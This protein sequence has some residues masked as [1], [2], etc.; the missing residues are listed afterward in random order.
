MPTP[1]PEPLTS[2]IGRFVFWPALAALLVVLGL[3]AWQTYTIASIGA[4]HPGEPQSARAAVLAA[5]PW[6]T[7]LIPLM[8]VTALAFWLPRRTPHSDDVLVLIGAGALIVIT[9][10]LATYLPCTTS[11]AWYAPV[12]W[13]LGLFTGAYEFSP[14]PPS[15]CATTWAPGLELARTLGLI[16]TG[17]TAL[18]LIHDFARSWVDR[19]VVALSG[20]VDVVAG[21]T[22]TSVPLVGALLD[23]SARSPRRPPWVDGR[24]L[25]RSHRDVPAALSGVPRG[26]RLA[27]WLTGLR[28]GDLRR[29]VKAR[30][31][32]VVIDSDGD[33]TLLD[34][35]RR[36]GAR[37]VV[38]D[39]TDER[40]LHSVLTRWSW[41]GRRRSALRRVF[42]VEDDQRRNLAIWAAVVQVMRDAAQTRL[43]GHLDD[44]VPRAFVLLAEAREARQ[45]RVNQ[46]AGLGPGAGAGAVG[47]GSDSGSGAAT[48]MLISDS[49][50]LD[51]LAA[52]QV[53][54]RILPDDVRLTE[55]HLVSR[56]VIVGDGPMALTL[57]DELAWQLWCRYEIAQAA[58][59]GHLAAQP[60]LVEITL[61]GPT[62][63]RRKAEWE[64]VR[65]PWC[66]PPS[67]RFLSGQG[68]PTALRMFEVLADTGDAEELASRVLAD[69][70]DA[71]VVFVDEGEEHAAAAAR[72][73]RL[74]GRPGWDAVRVM[75]RTPG[76]MAADP[77][78]PGGLLR[79]APELLRR[80]DGL[81]PCAPTDSVAR[82][83][84]QQH[85][86]Y[87][88]E[89]GFAEREAA[90]HG[91][92]APATQRPAATTSGAATA[93][94][95][96]V[97]GRR[98]AATAA[99]PVALLGEPLPAFYREDNV[100]QH[101][102]I[103]SWAVEHGYV[104][105]PVSARDAARH[106]PPHDWEP[107]LDEIVTA[108]YQRWAELRR[109]HGWW[110]IGGPT[111][112][113]GD[114]ALRDDSM[115]VHPELRGED[116]ISRDFNA[117]LI[118]TILH[119]LWASGLAAVRR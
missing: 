37:V 13:V 21:L 74:H 77:I 72:L 99:T 90:A 54:R 119:R 36:M 98:W 85:A 31:R 117:D 19:W 71:V 55:E 34:E 86:V 82:L 4:A 88:A 56:V 44:V 14:A 84:E 15:D 43:G 102:R 57:L 50:T 16:I 91:R 32:V 1:S 40:L 92:A 106:G 111:A 11:Q 95:P 68:A 33:N 69:D 75:L 116:F 101:W 114:A 104:W 80:D 49:L 17:S 45:W 96:K 9:L 108:E 30:T 10:G 38:G 58:G 26:Q 100:R 25:W 20:D 39:A 103:L 23:E 53:A 12:S 63:E 62:A 42:A 60:K 81:G 105:E 5:F 112:D 78:T 73:A 18:K 24:P 47:F 27:W 118:R 8:A 94:A 28:P 115:R 59:R 61:S 29:L 93:Y 48:P 110:A 79:F 3:L 89:T 65:A 51:G 66:Y 2:R 46:F 70:P 87:R 107:D 22:R 113:P 109:D 52:E 97:T 6:A 41:P 83:A 7:L 35:V 76:T 67:A 64:Q